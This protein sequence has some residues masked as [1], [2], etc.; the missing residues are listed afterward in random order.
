MTE[1][2]VIGGSE[3]LAQNLNA[4]AAFMQTDT[5]DWIRNFAVA[6]SVLV[7]AVRYTA[8][9]DLMD[10]LGWVFVLVFSSALLTKAQPV[11]IID[12][13]N[14]RSIQRVANVPLGIVL[15]ATII[16]RIG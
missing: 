10:I 5:W 9:R 12:L 8:R 7:L 15:P 13:S 6:I 4:V 11:Q 16:T 1:I 2:Y 3:W 14:Q